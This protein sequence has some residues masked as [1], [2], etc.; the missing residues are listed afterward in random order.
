MAGRYAQLVPVPVPE[1]R[2][3]APRPIHEVGPNP[4]LAPDRLSYTQ[5]STLLGC[6][7]AWV[8][9]HKSH[10]RVPDA[11]SV[12]TANQMLGI[13]AHKVVE[14]LQG[15]LRQEH[16]AV[17]DPAEVKA[18]VDRLLPQLASEL[19]LP[20]QLH[21]LAGV[22][23]TIETTVLTFFQ[24]LQRGG[25][26]LQE[27]EKEFSKDLTI[28]VGEADL[29]VAVKG[30]ADAVGI[31]AEGR[32]AVVDLKWS[33]TEKYFRADVQR[34]EALQLALY[35]WAL[36]D[37]EAPPDHP[38]AYFLLKQGIF[39]SAHPEFGTVLQ[40]SQNAPELWRRAVRAIE[41]TVEEVL[42]GRIT[43]AQPAE[44]ALAEGEPTA[45]A[46]AAENE[47]LHREPNCRYCNFGTLCGLKGDY[48]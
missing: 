28:S 45:A 24:Q 40:A 10:I 16:R 38:A 6:S 13:F 43:A 1:H 27:M 48:S 2:P 26:V 7:L 17:P 25:V 29:T 14:V 15:R 32:T 34:G 23:A 22:R 18:V 21:R 8:L 46:V 4:A 44:D 30:R 37:G 41:F 33:N 36:N 5:M 11:A 12:P 31:D 3:A 19:L 35:Q 20:G 42:A 9:K 39:A 47:R